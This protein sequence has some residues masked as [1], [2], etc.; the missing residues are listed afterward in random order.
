MPGQAAAGTA[1]ATLGAKG[2]GEALRAEL[3][4]Q[5]GGL[6]V[7]GTA[8]NEASARVVAT[9]LSDHGY[10]VEGDGRLAGLRAGT[11][12]LAGPLREHGRRRLLAPRG[13]RFPELAPAGHRAAGGG[14]QP[15]GG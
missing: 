7:A 9:V 3:Q 4:L 6:A 11:E 12:P 1:N 10:R 13:S 15:P 5:G 14:V 2:P 8:A